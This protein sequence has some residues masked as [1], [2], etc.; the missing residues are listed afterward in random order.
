MRTML[1]LTTPNFS[2]RVR[3]A[4]AIL[5]VII[6]SLLREALAPILGR[7]VP[8][9]LFYP[10]VAL[11]AWFGGFWPGISS[12]A[13]G[14]FIAWYVFIPPEFSF[15]VSEPTAAGQLIV[16]LLSSA[17]ICLLAE[18]LHQA[19]RTAQ[20]GEIR[21]REQRDQYRVTL[22]SISDAVI[23]TDAQGRVTFMNHVAESLT[24]WSY[25]Q[26]SGQPL[27]EVFKIVN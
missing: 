11:A 23:A 5:A 26:A 4:F 24:G 7:G 18:S 16:F 2:R 21:E 3:Y 14:G 17:F 20:E 25:E 12:T 1:T 19:T 6:A 22:A 8:F 13:L 10:T 9:I 15:M 27:D